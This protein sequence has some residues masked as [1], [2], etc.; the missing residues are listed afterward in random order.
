MLRSNSIY[1]KIVK[2]TKFGEKRMTLEQDD[3]AIAGDMDMGFGGED[4]V[5]KDQVPG[6]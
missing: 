3:D 1:D 2:T 4:F 6:Q 5:F